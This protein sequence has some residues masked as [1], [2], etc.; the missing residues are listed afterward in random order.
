MKSIGS[1]VCCELV[2][3][4]V[5][6][7]NLSVF[8]AVGDATNRLTEVSRVLGLVGL[9]GRE[10]LDDVVPRDAELLDDGA[11]RQE[12]ECVFDRHFVLCCCCQVNSD[13]RE[14]EKILRRHVEI[15]CDHG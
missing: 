1:V 11:L 4:A 13:R 5:Q 14:S 2:G 3:F 9:R 12:R 10:T 7:L 6:V 8:D 15:S